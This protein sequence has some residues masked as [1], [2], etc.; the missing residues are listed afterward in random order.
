MAS[1]NP[2]AAPSPR[3]STST[4]A[5]M[6]AAGGS[7][8]SA[9]RPSSVNRR[10]GAHQPSPAAL[11]SG[12]NQMDTSGLQPTNKRSSGAASP[13]T[14]GA[15][16]PKDT[17]AAAVGNGGSRRNTGR[18]S[19]G[20]AN[21]ATAWSSW[22]ATQL[23]DAAPAKSNVRT[24]PPPT[25]PAGSMSAT[26]HSSSAAVATAA[27][28]QE[29]P[30]SV[31]AAEEFPPIKAPLSLAPLKTSSPHLAPASPL[32]QDPD[33]S[34]SPSSVD[35][36]P[37]YAKSTIAARA[38]EDAKD[39]Q[40][41]RTIATP[42]TTRPP[43]SNSRRN[44]FSATG[45]I[46]VNGPGGGIPTHQSPNSNV[47]SPTG[48]RIVAG[49]APSD[50]A[51]RVTNQQNA[52]RSSLT[53]RD[54]GSPLPPTVPVPSANLSSPTAAEVRRRSGGPSPVAAAGSQISGT[55]SP[56]RE[57][58]APGGDVSS[59]QAGVAV[60]GTTAVTPYRA[61]TAAAP[62]S[63]TPPPIDP[64]NPAALAQARRKAILSYLHR[65]TLLATG[66]EYASTT[67][68]GK[69][70]SD[71]VE[72]LLNRAASTADLNKGV[73]DTL[74]ALVHLENSMNAQGSDFFRDGKPY[75]NLAE[76]LQP[77]EKVKD[78]G[79][80]KNSEDLNSPEQSPAL[81]QARRIMLEGEQEG[82]APK[83]SDHDT[84]APQGRLQPLNPPG[85]GGKGVRVSPRNGSDDGLSVELHQIKSAP[86][87]GKKLAVV[88]PNQGKTPKNGDSDEE[89]AKT[90]PKFALPKLTSQPYAPTPRPHRGSGGAD[91]SDEDKDVAF[92]LAR[93]LGLGAT[94]VPG[95]DGPTSP[96]RPSALSS[97][98]AAIRAELARRVPPSSF[99]WL[100]EQAGCKAPAKVGKD[101]AASMEGLNEHDAQLRHYLRQLEFERMRFPD[102]L[103]SVLPPGHFSKA[104][105]AQGAGGASASS[106][107]GSTPSSTANAAHGFDALCLEVRRAHLES[108][109]LKSALL[110][111]LLAHR[112]QLGLDREIELTQKEAE[113]VYQHGGGKYARRVLEILCR[114]RR[115]IEL[116]HLAAPSSVSPPSTFMQFDHFLEVARETREKFEASRAIETTF[117]HRMLT[118]TRAGKKLIFIGLEEDV[119]VREA[120]AFQLLE[121]AAASHA[122]THK[123]TIAHSP[124]AAP[125]VS[126]TAASPTADP[127]VTPV[128]TDSEEATFD[129]EFLASR[130]S[131]PAPG[132]IFMA[133][134]QNLVARDLPLFEGGAALRSGLASTLASLETHESARFIA[135]LTSLEVKGTSV[136]P[137]VRQVEEW[138]DEMAS[139]GFTA[140]L[141]LQLWRIS[142]WK[143]EPEASWSFEKLRT[144]CLQQVMEYHE[145]PLQVE[146]A[147]V[148]AYLVNLPAPLYSSGDPA[149][150]MC[151]SYVVDQ[152]LEI[153]P[154]KVGRPFALSFTLKLLNDQQIHLSGGLKE[155]RSIF[156]K[157]REPQSLFA[158]VQALDRVAAAERL[159]TRKQLA[160]SRV[161]DG[162]IETEK[163]VKRFD[164]SIR[165]ALAS[166]LL[167][168]EGH[169]NSP[170]RFFLS[171]YTQNLPFMQQA[172][173]GKKSPKSSQH[174]PQLTIEQAA[175]LFL[176]EWSFSKRLIHLLLMSLPV[177]SLS[178]PL[179]PRAFFHAALLVE[180]SQI[181]DLI[182]VGGGPRETWYTL[183]E[184]R[185]LA[186]ATPQSQ[187]WPH[188]LARAS[189]ARKRLSKQLSGVEADWA[190]LSIAHH[191]LL[192]YFRSPT[193]RLL[194]P[195]VSFN[196]TSQD[197]DN[198]LPAAGG[199]DPFHTNFVT[200][201]HLLLQ[202]DSLDFPAKH[203]CTSVSE[204]VEMVSNAR[205][206]GQAKAR[207]LYSHLSAPGCML[208]TGAPN[209]ILTPSH[210]ERFRRYAGQGGMSV[211]VFRALGLE[212][213]PKPKEKLGVSA[214][215]A[216][217]IRARTK[218]ASLQEASAV[219]PS[220][221]SA[222]AS[223]A[224]TEIGGDQ[225]IVDGRLRVRRKR[226]LQHLRLV[227][228]RVQ[229][230]P[231]SPSRR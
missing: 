28:N 147:L 79:L 1:T 198:L 129:A 34:L 65:S 26:N 149:L 51:A 71:Q 46:V 134:M 3:N 141:L 183:M 7:S 25:A 173:K 58:V 114:H 128:P 47:I 63:S 175:H 86:S 161:P 80:L 54:S 170:L 184:M 39:E 202:L 157:F 176:A 171:H 17:G 119:E 132:L 182:L 11:I 94:E 229:L 213:K 12:S 69:S 61:Q 136:K 154:K 186:S 36:T 21:A 103:P 199:H 78:S 68:G 96:V 180:E 179:V 97:S 109:A 158:A 44:S 218:L 13:A 187:D 217:L 118:R 74:L 62:S 90:Q 59:G 91:G 138:M 20:G 5:S 14:N 143:N 113:R 225:A 42:N 223:A 137:R 57:F 76:L 190:G 64:S 98:P 167:A 228:P 89:E 181:D 23:N 197:L 9:S 4:S 30:R 142:P 6:N 66:W 82:W 93:A 101:A 139:E 49:W 172:E 166:S 37:I 107:H 205:V 153:L 29:P 75:A 92:L 127:S 226:R 206:E 72:L 8:N 43:L 105:A 194:P 196:L 53:S 156:A 2:A 151:P 230:L 178:S 88:K 50:V 102:P 160:E 222:A 210:V 159:W 115:C 140:T 146:R 227:L 35:E 148:H 130:P 191:H 33:D 41:E 123:S 135:E 220:K 200:V 87:G 221:S 174:Q 185:S 211:G 150:P 84:W 111:F 81:Q 162:E 145:D 155:G 208:F 125:V 189:S 22:V 207:A 168:K 201:F 32:G 48:E 216:F 133:A 16:T 95:Q 122:A 204:L 85:A 112:V 116:S 214:F 126:P 40:R 83:Q 104:A 18:R 144:Y 100:R 10:S 219:K 165:L 106:P 55:A 19:S 164:S 73:E 124:T 120:D 70:L 188:F 193:S 52:K 117:V 195:T 24:G 231:H 177:S 203:L 121:L 110:E 45:T 38:K 131:G 56:A 27:A 163:L 224:A 215:S 152:L 99:E 77:I 108:F 209:F 60:A 169:I 212:T 192:T 15:A 67:Q 31:S